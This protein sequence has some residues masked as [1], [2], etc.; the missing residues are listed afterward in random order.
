MHIKGTP[1]TMQQDPHYDDLFGEIIA[2]L[3]DSIQLGE[4]AGIRQM[5]VDPGIGFGKRREHNLELI[6]AL[7]RFSVLGRPILVGPSRK[8]FI[9]ELLDLPVGERLEGTLAAVTACILSGANIIRVH[10]VKASKR[11]ATIADAI[12]RASGQISQA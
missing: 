9:G 10:D 4:A 3:R 12:R 5:I 1:R 8:S 11:A 6:G 7:S 2:F